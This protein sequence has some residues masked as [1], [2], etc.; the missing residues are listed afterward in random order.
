MS[1]GSD[2]GTEMGITRRSKPCGFLGKYMPDRENS[3]CKS[4]EVGAILALWRRRVALSEIQEVG[5]VWIVLPCEPQERVSSLFH[6]HWEVPGM[7][8][9]I[10]YRCEDGPWSSMD[11]NVPSDPSPHPASRA[12]FPLPVSASQSPELEQP[13]PGVV[14]THKYRFLASLCCPPNFWRLS[15][16]KNS[17][18]LYR[19][20]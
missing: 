3:T 18:W 17:R 16:L 19:H 2:I 13:P 7:V 15:R 5:R 20:I 4:P 14:S 12:Q 10:G 9:T 8:G 6:R 1:Q 11:N